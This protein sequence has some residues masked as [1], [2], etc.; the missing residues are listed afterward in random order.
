MLNIALNK[1]IIKKTKTTLVARVANPKISLVKNK[2]ILFHVK[3][4]TFTDIF[5]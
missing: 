2:C 3:F 4:F 5:H 1:T